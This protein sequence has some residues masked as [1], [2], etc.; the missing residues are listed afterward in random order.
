VDGRWKPDRLPRGGNLH[1]GSTGTPTVIIE[2]AKLLSNC[3]E[4]RLAEPISKLSD[5]PGVTEKLA[6]A[7]QLSQELT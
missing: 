4:F 7:T 5:L 2:S 6:V 3:E 1:C